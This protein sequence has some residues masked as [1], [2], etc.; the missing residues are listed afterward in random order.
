MNFLINDLDCKGFFQPE[1]KKD[2]MI[3]NIYSIYNKM[4]LSKK[5]LRMLWG[6]HK[7]LI[8]LPKL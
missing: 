8:N 6:I 3:D 2:S 5:E 1:E 7:K 4:D